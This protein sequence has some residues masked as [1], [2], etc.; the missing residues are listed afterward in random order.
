MSWWYQPGGSPRLSLAIHRPLP[1]RAGERLP[2]ERA[3]G[4]H[5]NVHDLSWGKTQPAGCLME[6][7]G[8]W[9][10]SDLLF[11]ELLKD[12]ASSV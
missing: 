2:L 7:R 10:S 11:K 9:E 6:S 5:S 12:S 8:Q 4:Q 1:A 3:L